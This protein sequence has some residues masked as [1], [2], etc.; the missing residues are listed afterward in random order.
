MV[1]ESFGAQV[2]SLNKGEGLINEQVGSEFTKGLSEKVIQEK[3]DIGLAHDGDG[4][5]IV[6]IDRNAEQN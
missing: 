4:D 5:R 2:I 3:A 6:F 1:L